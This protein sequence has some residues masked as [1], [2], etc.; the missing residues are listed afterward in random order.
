MSAM[1][2]YGNQPIALEG[3]SQTTKRAA[4][5]VPACAAPVKLLLAYGATAAILNTVP[6]PLTSWQE[7]SPPAVVVP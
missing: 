4:R 7:K 5:L 3:A 6:Q 1:A 2:I